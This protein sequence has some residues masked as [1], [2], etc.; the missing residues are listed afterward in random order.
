MLT[1]I[2][3][4]LDNPDDIPAIPHAASQFIQARL[5]MAYLVRSGQL[6]ALRR[7]GFSESAILGFLEGVSVAIEVL[8]LM[9]EAQRQKHE[10]EQITL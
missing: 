4:H 7:A 3:H 10:D 2:Q 1:Q 9:E 5:N 8:E 6:D